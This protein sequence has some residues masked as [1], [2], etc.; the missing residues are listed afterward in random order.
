M[1]VREPSDDDKASIVEMMLEGVPFHVDEEPLDGV[2][3]RHVARRGAWIYMTMLKIDRAS[4]GEHKFCPERYV[5]WVRKRF[6]NHLS[7][8]N[9]NHELLDEIVQQWYEKY[10]PHAMVKQVQES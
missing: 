9:R 2:A 10:W 6:L 7:G 8:A 5:N 1:R 4:G 3:R